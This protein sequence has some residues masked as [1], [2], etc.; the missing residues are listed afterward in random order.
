MVAT[1]TPEMSH[2]MRTTVRHRR[3]PHGTWCST[4]ATAV[5]TTMPPITVAPTST[6]DCDSARWK[7]SLANSLVY[8]LKPTNRV[9]PVSGWVEVRDIHTPRSIG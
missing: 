5:A 3:P 1:A 4:S 2:G 6:N 7:S 9:T 8:W